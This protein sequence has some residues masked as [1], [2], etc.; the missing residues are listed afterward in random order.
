M[1]RI[2]LWILLGFTFVTASAQVK[3]LSLQLENILFTDL[4]DTLERVVPARFYYS[5]KWV[6][7]LI[8]SLNATDIPFN[9]TVERALSG[10]GLSFFITEDDRVILSKGYSVRTGFGDEYLDYLRRNIRSQDTLI[11]QNLPSEKPYSEINDETRIFRIGRQSESSR[12]MTAVLS[13][14]IFSKYDG[15]PVPPGQSYM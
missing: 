7:S 4:I 5:D 14:T 9:K 1:K 10:S 12:G 13:G 6:D 11:R 8:L 15:E 3:T 2:F